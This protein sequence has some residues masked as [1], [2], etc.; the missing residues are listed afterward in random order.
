MIQTNM[1]YIEHDAEAECINDK[2]VML[3]IVTVPG[4]PTG[5]VNISV[6]WPACVVMNNCGL[7]LQPLPG[8]M[9]EA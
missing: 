7:L 2:C 9:V 8:H 1:E 4:P 3:T 6:S 5:H